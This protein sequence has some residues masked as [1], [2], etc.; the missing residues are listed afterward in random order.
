MKK[1]KVII[2]DLDGTLLNS[3]KQVSSRNEKALIKCREAGC[4]LWIATARPP[5]SVKR[6]VPESILRAS[7]VIY[8]NGA[9]VLD[10]LS[11]I[12]AHYPIP[13]ADSAALINY[14]L[15]HS[16]E[17]TLSLEVEDRWYANKAAEDPSL[18][19]RD[20]SPMLCDLEQMLE[21][22]PS[23][24]LIS[25]MKDSLYDQ[26]RQSFT[27]TVNVVLTDQGKLLQI[28]HPQV[29]KSKAASQLARHYGYELSE[30][31]VFGDDWNDL[32]LFELCG[33]SVAMGNA[34]QELKDRAA[35]ITKT[36]D[37]DGV[38]VVLERWISLKDK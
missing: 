22:S 19:N 28:M 37:E 14:C 26:L 21:Y 6:F 12:K 7:S 35:E 10:H 8:Y 9:F 11:G 25:G 2:V 15:E 27:S 38:A 1:I 18:Y 13:P 30:A 24:I 29:S 3:Q 4:L 33:H 20:S 32:D 31:M 16:P 5:R 23:K 36:N 34:I 17:C